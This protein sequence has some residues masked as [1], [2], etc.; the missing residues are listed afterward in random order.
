MASAPTDPNDAVP[1]DPCQV[2]TFV[3]TLPTNNDGEKNNMRSSQRVS[4]E[5]AAPPEP[6]KVRTFLRTFPKKNDEKRQNETSQGIRVCLYRPYMRSLFNFTNV[7]NA[8][9]SLELA[10]RRSGDEK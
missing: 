5:N 4:Y 7:I 2:R 1:P 3:G 8:M 6:W 9:H 10:M